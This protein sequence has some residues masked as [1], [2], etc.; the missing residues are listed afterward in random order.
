MEKLGKL[1]LR[2][3]TNACLETGLH[4]RTGLTFLDIVAQAVVGLKNLTCNINSQTDNTVGITGFVVM[5]GK[6][7]T[8][9]PSMTM[10]EIASIVEDC[11]T[12]L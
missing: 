3:T 11:G 4:Q 8:T 9:L 2:K 10:E 5:P 6:A 1:H 7:L 12:P